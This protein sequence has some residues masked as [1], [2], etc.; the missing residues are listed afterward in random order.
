MKTYMFFL[1]PMF[2]KKGLESMDTTVWWSIVGTCSLL[3]AVAVGTVVRRSCKG[4]KGTK[5]Q[6]RLPLAVIYPV[7]SLPVAVEVQQAS[8]QAATEPVLT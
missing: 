4:C 2:Q 3:M 7:S 6:H 5:A 8:T 1:P